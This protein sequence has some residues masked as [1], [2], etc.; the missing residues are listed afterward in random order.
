MASARG[1]SNNDQL[2]EYEQ[3]RD[4]NIALNNEML[5]S[6]GIPPMNTCKEQPRKRAKVISYINGST[7]M[8]CSFNIADIYT[9]CST[10][11]F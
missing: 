9:N 3:D 7:K 4:E 1:R 2:T 8:I 10:T 5:A 6:L 11:T